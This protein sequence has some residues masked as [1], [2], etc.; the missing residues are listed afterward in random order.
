MGFSTIKI[1]DMGRKST[2]VIPGIPINGWTP[3]QPDTSTAQSKTGKSHKNSSWICR[4]KCGKINPVR[5]SNLVR[6]SS[7]NCGC[8]RKIPR[9]RPYES[10][11]NRFVHKN[12]KRF[13][14]ELTYEEFITF[15]KTSGCH[16]CGSAVQ[17]SEYNI[18][19]KGNGYNLDRKDNA[20]GYL[21]ENLVVCCPRCNKARSDLFTYEQFVELGAVMKKWDIK[22]PVQ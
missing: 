17:W 3:I 15:T 14:V 12:E 10:L 13:P 21:I 18:S 6:G 16:Y 19:K 1:Y 20:L 8:E 9:K 22:G 4:C 11:Y 2:T 7:R 5:T